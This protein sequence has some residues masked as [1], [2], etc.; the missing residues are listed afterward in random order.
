[1]SH[2]NSAPKKRNPIWIVLGIFA[3][4]FAVGLVLCC[5]IGLWIIQFPSV[6]ADAATSFDSDSIAVPTFPQKGTSK[7]FP[8]TAIRT[9]LVLGDGSGYGTPA[10]ANSR[11]WIYLPEQKVPVASLPCVLICGA[12]STMLT[13]MRLGDGDEPEHLPYVAAGFAVVAYDLDGPGMTEEPEVK[14]YEAF[15]SSNA[16][17]VNARNAMEYALTQ[18]PEVN[19]KQIFAVGHSSAG[20]TALLFAA[21]EPRLAGCVAFAPCSDL[22]ARFPGFVVRGL[23][24]TFQG[25]PEFLVKSSAR[26][27]EQKLHCPVMLF[28]AADDSNVPIQESRDFVARLKQSGKDATLLEVPTG[29]HYEP[30][31]STGIPAGIAW[32]K[33]QLK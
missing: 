33:K 22:K 4:V 28:H 5:G 12:G 11:L 23:S 9:E 6:S 2:A 30:M 7:R 3:G 8:G 25:L 19:P 24:T 13:G 16:G 27:H 31:I 10:G 26:T 21:H 29:D 18:I 32:M 1:M 17:L 14:A 20:G 15:R